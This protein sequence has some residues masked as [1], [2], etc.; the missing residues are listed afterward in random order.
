MQKK[1][2]EILSFHSGV[3]EVQD[4]TTVED[5]ITALSQ[6]VG[7]QFSS[8]AASNPRRTGSAIKHFSNKV[9]HLQRDVCVRHPHF[10]EN[11]ANGK[12]KS[13]ERRKVELIIIK[14]VIKPQ[15][16]TVTWR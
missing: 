8:D 2:R 15:A 16:T 6:K 1:L 13:F 12:E 10:P 11:W 4:I 7:N 5:V 3:A 14:I 9:P